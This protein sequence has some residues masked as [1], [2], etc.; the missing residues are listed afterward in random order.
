MSGREGQVTSGRSEWL[1]ETRS[2]RVG[3]ISSSA[4]VLSCR[5]DQLVEALA[6]EDLLNC[7]NPMSEIRSVLEVLANSLGSAGC[8]SWKW[9][10][11][12]LEV[13]WIQGSRKGG[14]GQV[15]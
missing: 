1:E 14:G 5:S 9:C 4:Q 13:L 6:A 7:W 2:A 3:L 12:L 11:T 10:L 15:R 8:L